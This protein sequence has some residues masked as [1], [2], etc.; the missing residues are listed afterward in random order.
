MQ[1]DFLLELLKDCK[2]N[3]IHTTL[4]TSGF[5]DSKKL[6]KL[7]P[8]TD[9]FLYDLKLMDD[10]AH[11][12]FAGVSNRIILEN[13]V[14]LVSEEKQVIIRIPII[15]GITDTSQNIM[16]MKE[17]LTI[18]AKGSKQKV[19]FQINLL[20]YHSIAKNKYLRLSIDNKTADLKD[21]AKETLM[22]LKNEFESEGFFVKIG[23]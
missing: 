23:G 14:F 19:P 20:P 5:G 9:L 17:F 18:L 4:D 8:Y 22:P 7:L 3:S 21:I 12:R 15:P 16:E 11:I 6:K 10:K 1:A 13:L 2:T